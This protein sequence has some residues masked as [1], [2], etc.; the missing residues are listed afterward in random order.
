LNTI[1]GF[2]SGVI[3]CALGVYFALDWQEE[4]LEFSISSPAKFG[5]TN[6]QNL[7]IQNIGWNPAENLKIIISHPTITF[8]NIQSDATLKELKSDKNGIANLNRLRR[9]ETVVISVVYEGIPLTSDNIKVTSNRSIAKAV[10][11]NSKDSFLSLF[12]NIL[13]MLTS[14]LSG[15]LLTTLAFKRWLAI[16][17]ELSN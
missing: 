10:E 6:Y 16:P 2:I 3:I 9:D 13:A 1:I 11:V 14:I 17:K 7:T 15:V 5:E 12:N 8:K 4:K